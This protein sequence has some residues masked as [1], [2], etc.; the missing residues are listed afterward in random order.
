MNI[1]PPQAKLKAWDVQRFQLLDGGKV[2]SQPAWTIVPPDRGSIND[3]G[4]YTSPRSVFVSRT[5][6]VI[7]EAKNASNQDEKVTAVITLSNERTWIASLVVFLVLMALGSLWGVFSVWPKTLA[8]SP[9][10]LIGPSSVVLKKGDGQIFV[11]SGEDPIQ[12]FDDAPAGRFEAKTD[13]GKFV[14]TA[15]KSQH[16]DIEAHAT[17]TIADTSLSITPRLPTLRSGETIKL[18]AVPPLEDAVWHGEFC[19]VDG[20][21]KAPRE[22][23]E[24]Q[25]VAATVSSKANPG[26]RAAVPIRLIPDPPRPTLILVIAMLFGALGALLHA[27]NS[28]IAFVGS[29]KFVSSW[30]LFYLARPFVGAIMALLVLAVF[31]GQL[32]VEVVSTTDFFSV[33]AICGLVGMFSDRSAEKLK[34]VFDVVLGPKVDSR[35]NKLSN[36]VQAGSAATKPVIASVTPD[37]LAAGSAVQLLEVKGS[38]FSAKCKGQINGKNRVATVQSET[39]LS[40]ALEAVDVS[41]PE[42]L[43][44]T[45]LSPGG[46]ASNVFLVTVA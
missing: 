9:R 23:F 12:W 44:V 15:S 27:I 5:V 6:I 11:A 20:S 35:A 37:K 38:G 19:K 10:L 17:V 13:A 22:V 1:D 18:E 4:A 46:D 42:M 39:Q 25:V 21:C 8:R 41:A 33:A 2:V 7:A 28:F 40:I 14:V 43:A 24:E 29:E 3:A 31:K 45:V 26:L 32:A 34:E 16:P 36:N 30:G